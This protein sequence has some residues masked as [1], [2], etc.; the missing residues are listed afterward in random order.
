MCR[1]IHFISLLAVEHLIC[2]EGVSGSNPL[3]STDD[4]KPPAEV[5]Y[6]VEVGARRR[7][8]GSRN[9]PAGRYL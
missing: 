4:R 5:I 3:G 9:F 8:T 7:E 1:R 6:T 2:N